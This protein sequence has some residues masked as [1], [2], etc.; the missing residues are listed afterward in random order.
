M[1][2][3]GIIHA[4]KS[5]SALKLSAD[6]VTDASSFFRSSITEYLLHVLIKI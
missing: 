3:Q 5:L 2:M 6:F 1:P 4:A